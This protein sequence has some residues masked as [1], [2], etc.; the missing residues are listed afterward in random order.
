MLHKETSEAG[1]LDLIKG[2]NGRRLLK[3]FYQDAR[4]EK[5]GTFVLHGR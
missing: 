3:I 5:P 2:L 4:R 1:T